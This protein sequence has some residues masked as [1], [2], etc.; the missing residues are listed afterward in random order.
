LQKENRALEA[1]IQSLRLAIR[2]LESL[3]EDNKSL[4]EANSQ[5]THE[6]EYK[7]KEI[8]K[9]KQSLELKES[10]IDEYT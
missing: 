10:S 4:E 3:T 5:L 8:K 6:K 9:L 7:D 1:T 2:N